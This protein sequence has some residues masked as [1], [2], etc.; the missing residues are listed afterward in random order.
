MTISKKGEGEWKGGGWRGRGREGERKSG[1]KKEGD[2]EE[3]YLP[4]APATTLVVVVL[5]TARREVHSG[6]L[7]S[8]SVVELS[9]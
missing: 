9:A 1:I 6:P 2:K 7:P 4:V 3:F 5:N 8:S